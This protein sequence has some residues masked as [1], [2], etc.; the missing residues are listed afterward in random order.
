MIASYQPTDVNFVASSKQFTC[1]YKTQRPSVPTCTRIGDGGGLWRRT[2]CARKFSTGLKLK[3]VRGRA[4]K[5]ERQRAAA[6]AYPG[7]SYAAETLSWFL[8]RDSRL[9]S[10]RSRWF[11]RTVPAPARSPGT[12][13]AGAGFKSTGDYDLTQESLRSPPPVLRYQRDKQT[14]EASKSRWSPPSMDTRNPK[15]NSSPLLATRLEMEYLTGGSG[16]LELSLTG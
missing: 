16:P 5:L 3:R 11:E 4:G 7:P 1:S 12:E 10:T 9:N 2:R 14:R 15:R 8:L 6:S 13:G